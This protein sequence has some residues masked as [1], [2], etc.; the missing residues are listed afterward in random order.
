VS[1]LRQRLDAFEGELPEPLWPALLEDAIRI[2]A[3][4]NAP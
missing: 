3:P 1:E 2:D 4:L